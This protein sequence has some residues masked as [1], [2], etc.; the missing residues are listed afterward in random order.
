MK[1]IIPWKMQLGPVTGTGF[2]PHTSPELPP[3]P[4]FTALSRPL[5]VRPGK[6]LEVGKLSSRD[7]R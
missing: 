6:V 1:S 7:R 2:T 3:T 5:L 4:S